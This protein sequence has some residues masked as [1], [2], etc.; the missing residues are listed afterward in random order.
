MT[1]LPKPLTKV[2]DLSPGDCFWYA[3]DLFIVVKFSRHSAAKVADMLGANR[4][5]GEVIAVALDD[6]SPMPFHETTLVEIAPHAR[7]LT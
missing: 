1:V 2:T 3:A 7:V 6:G 5:G 4:E